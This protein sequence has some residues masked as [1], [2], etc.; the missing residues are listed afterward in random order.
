MAA[1]CTTPPCRH[2]RG[3]STLLADLLV[4][5]VSGETHPMRRLPCECK[6]CEQRTCRHT[7]LQSLPRRAY[8]PLF[9]T[10]EEAALLQVGMPSTT[11]S[12][13]VNNFHVA[14]MFLSR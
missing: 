6:C 14:M 8:L 4:P 7:Y 10:A 11:L 3:H 2:A 1:V 12:N 13:G 9:W 5:S